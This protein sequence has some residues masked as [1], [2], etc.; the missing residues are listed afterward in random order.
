V[1]FWQAA[2]QSLIRREVQDIVASEFDG[3]YLDIV[4]AFEYF[5]A[6]AR[7]DSTEEHPTNPSTGRSYRADMKRWIKT[8]ATRARTMR[9]GFLVVPQNGAQLLDD[10]KYIELSDGTFVSL[11]GL[12]HAATFRESALA[13][14]HVQAFLSPAYPTT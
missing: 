9:P 10:K 12:D 2:W 6:Q 14:P 7:S 4:D 3:V 1:K 8:V 11:D 5:E 13:L